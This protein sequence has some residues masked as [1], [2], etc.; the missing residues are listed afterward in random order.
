M[1]GQV[2]PEPHD[3]GHRPVGNKSAETAVFIG[4]VEDHLRV[5]RHA[6]ELAQVA[7][8]PRILHQPFKVLGAHQH[9]FFR[10][11]SEKDLFKYWPLGVHHA[12]LEPRAKYA[13]GQGRQVAIVADPAQLLSRFGNGQFGFQGG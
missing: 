7:D 4:Y 11:E 1:L 10:I 13:Q 3:I 9:H 5:A 8:D 2:L 12:V 6:F